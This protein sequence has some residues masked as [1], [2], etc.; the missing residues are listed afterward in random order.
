MSGRHPAEDRQGDDDGEDVP[1]RTDEHEDDENPWEPRHREERVEDPHHQ[2]VRL[3]PREARD[4]AVDEP[5]EENDPDRHEGNEHRVPP[6]ERHPL[7]QVAAEEIGAEQ[8]LGAREAEL[9][10]EVDGV[11]VV[12]REEGC[13]QAEEHQRAEPGGTPHRCAG[14]VVP[15][16]DEPGFA[17][18]VVAL[19]AK[20]ERV[21]NSPRLE[22]K[23]A[24]SCP[25]HEREGDQHDDE[26]ERDRPEKS[27]KDEGGHAG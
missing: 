18:A 25:A 23:R 26:D 12:W 24:A 5:E 14:G 13:E 8:V 4:G 9:V 7:G 21:G 15:E 2:L 19:E 20:L 6:A 22:P 10:A 11:G 27:P 1:T 3:S 16:L 17:E